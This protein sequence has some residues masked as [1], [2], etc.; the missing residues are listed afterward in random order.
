MSD[1]NILE[2]ENV[3]KVYKTGDVAFEAL[4]EVSLVIER[5][6]WV[7][8]QGPSGSG[9]STLLNL[10]GCLDR[11][12]S[13]RV[14]LEGIDISKL[15]ENKLAQMRGEKI[16][17]IFQTFNLIPSLTVTENILLPTSFTR[18]LK[19]ADAKQR[20]KELMNRLGINS[21]KN[22]FPS[23]LSGGETQRVAI[24]R[25]LINEPS[26][27][28]ADEPTGNL[29][30]TTGSE[31]ANLFKEMHEEGETIILV[32][33]DNDLARRAEKIYVLRD[34]KLNVKGE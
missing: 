24:G 10:I 6:R 3:G 23:R 33:H 30:T 27:I 7:A 15:S 29:D 26:L 13:G 14:L 17:F 1:S 28:L 8:I 34:G 20:V 32:T 16:G 2:L 18:K 12:T 4:H 11:P 5:G 25:A 22:R 31:I 9:K 21:L 19:K